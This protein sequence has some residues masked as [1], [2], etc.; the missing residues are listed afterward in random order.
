M[1]LIVTCNYGALLAET[2]RR[3]E[4]LAILRHADHLFA[5]QKVFGAVNRQARER[6]LEGFRR[7]VSGGGVEA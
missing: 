1:H 5:S 3:E 7:K 6:A 4:A 2:G